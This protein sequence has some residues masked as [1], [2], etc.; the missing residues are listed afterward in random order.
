MTA[1]TSPAPCRQSGAEVIYFLS[2]PTTFLYTADAL[3]PGYNPQFVGPGI[4]SGLNTVAEIGCARPRK[5]VDKA[6]FLSPFPQLDVINQIDPG[7]QQAYQA[8]QKKNGDDLGL[9]LWGLSKQLKV[10]FD[11]AGKDMSRQSFVTA[12][13]S[14]QALRRRRVPTRHLHGPQPLRWQ[15]GARPPGRLRHRGS[16]KTIAT[17]VSGF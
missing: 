4:T 13:E 17:F 3:Q 12:I 7:Y 10:M 8:Q 1:P 14:G 16:F 9:A 15:P 2:S 6:I 11:A 5:G